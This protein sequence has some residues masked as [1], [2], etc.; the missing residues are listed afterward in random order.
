VRVP[1]TVALVLVALVLAGQVS[2]RDPKDPQQRHTA[3]DTALARSIALK[4]SDLAAG[5]TKAPA[6]K[7]GPPC[8]AE[9]DESK[10]VQ[11]ARIDPTFVWRDRVTSVGSEVDIFRTAAQAREDWRMSTLRVAE[12]CLLQSARTEVG[13]HGTVSVISATNL[14]PPRQGKRSFHYRLVFEV[15]AKRAVPFVS[16]LIAVGSGRISVV[17]HLFKAG[18]PPAASELSPLTSLLAKRLAAATSH[19]AI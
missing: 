15:R 1:V 19:G 17:L 5:W 3:A 12:L 8:R 10:L 2:A 11:T 6:D 18:A 7:P 4:R 9:P 14:L 13:K 16:E